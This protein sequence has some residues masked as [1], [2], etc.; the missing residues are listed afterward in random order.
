MLANSSAASGPAKAAVKKKAPKPK[1]STKEKKERGLL[2]ERVA[3]ALPLEFRGGDL[4]LR[5]HVEQVSEGF[6]DHP[7]RG[8]GSASLPL[9]FLCVPC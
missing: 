9:S 5:R 1:L 7:G 6:L 8:V 4:N 3:N 2:L